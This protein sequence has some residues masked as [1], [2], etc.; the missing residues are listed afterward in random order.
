MTD[1]VLRG[2]IVDTQTLDLMTDFGREGFGLG[3]AQKNDGGAS[4]YGHSGSRSGYGAA[5]WFDPQT[6]ATIVALVNADA[7][8]FLAGTIHQ[9]MQEAYARGDR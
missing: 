4:L 7:P 6:K 8:T 5:A 9:R 2:G 1:A 3:V